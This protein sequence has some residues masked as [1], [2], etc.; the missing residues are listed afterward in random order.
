MIQELNMKQKVKQALKA[1]DVWKQ[2][3]LMIRLNGAGVSNA[4]TRSKF[5]VSP[6]SSMGGSPTH[7]TQRQALRIPKGHKPMTTSRDRDIFAPISGGLS[8]AF[9]TIALN[10]NASFSKRASTFF[11]PLANEDSLF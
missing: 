5:S 7:K 8:T 11:D 4:L 10:N 1:T 6:S 9:R 2:D 3:Q